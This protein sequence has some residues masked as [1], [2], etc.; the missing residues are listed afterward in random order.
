VHF[1]IHAILAI[2]PHGNTSATSE[3]QYV[4]IPRRECAGGGFSG[5]HP[6]DVRTRHVLEDEFPNSSGDPLVAL[7][8]NHTQ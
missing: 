3:Q 7:D 6:A 5:R 2:R 1:R 4:H 8:V